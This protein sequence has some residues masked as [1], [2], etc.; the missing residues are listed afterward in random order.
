MH[1][2]KGKNGTIIIYNSDLNGPLIIN[3]QEVNGQD[4]YD[5][6]AQYAKKETKRTS[7]AIEKSLTK[8]NEILTL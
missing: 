1:T 8:D 2:F 7:K 3:G 4:V 5:F 6:I